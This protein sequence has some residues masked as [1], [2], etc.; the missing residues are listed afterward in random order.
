MGLV[1]SIA[2]LMFVAIF[3]SHRGIGIDNREVEATDDEAVAVAVVDSPQSS[4]VGEADSTPQITT[5]PAV[6]DADRPNIH[7]FL[8]RVEYNNNVAYLLGSMH[9]GR[10]NWFPLSPIVEEAMARSDVFAIETT[11]H[12]LS[13]MDDDIDLDDISAAA[14]IEAFMEVIVIAVIIE[15]LLL[16]PYDDMTLED[17]L[18]PRGFANLM[19]ML[20]TYPDVTYEDIYF[21]TPRAALSALMADFEQYISLY[22]DYSVDFYTTNFAFANN[23]PVIGLNDI[24]YEMILLFDKP[25]EGQYTLFDNFQPRDIALNEYIQ[26]VNALIEAYETQDAERIRRILFEGIQR[27]HSDFTFLDYDV[28]VYRTSIYAEETLRLL[29]ETEEPTTFFITVGAFHI[30]YGHLFSILE[31]NGL[32]IVELWR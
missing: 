8:S 7:G 32:E 11:M 10:E 3:T 22:I 31:E 2:L 28:F 23:K 30:L 18:S 25:L 27:D 12:F 14:F 26:D 6:P 9:M 21:L 13:M 20:E 5:S 1:F 19:E 17:V 4:T 15:E 16:L 29:R 24:F